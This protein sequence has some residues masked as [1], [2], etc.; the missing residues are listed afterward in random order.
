MQSKPCGYS[1][2]VTQ[3]AAFRTTSSNCSRCGSYP[4]GDILCLAL[5]SCLIFALLI[6]Q[7]VKT[8]HGALTFPGAKLRKLTTAG[9][10]I[11]ILLNCYSSSLI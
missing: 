11:L 8:A 4:F 10:L 9:L 1:V 6:S 7:N 5:D 2:F 3:V